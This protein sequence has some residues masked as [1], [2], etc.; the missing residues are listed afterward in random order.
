MAVTGTVHSRRYVLKEVI[1]QGGMGVVYR[2]YD[3]ETR[4]DVTLKT[5][6]DISNPAM[7][8][9]FRKECDVLAQLN[10]P[11]I[12]DIYDI[13]EFVD[14]AGK[15]QPYFVMPLLPGAT[16]DRLIAGGS[17]RLA[18]E[19]T[20]EI[21]VQACRGLHAA[22]ERGLIHR[23][24][25]PSNI[26]VLEDDSVKLIDFGVAHLSTGHSQTSVK[27][28][29]HY[30]APEQLQSRKPTPASDLFSLGVV[31]YEALT[32]RKPFEG[33]SAD[34]VVQAIL[35]QNPP[36][37]SEL[38]PSVNRTLSQVI[39]K[40]LAKHPLHRFPSMRDFGENL[41]KALRGETIEIF[42]ESRMLARIERA[43]RALLTG[44]LEFA[45]EILTGLEAEGYTHPDMPPM[46]RDIDRAQREK[47]IT[48][49]LESAG[50]CFQEDEYQL[51]LQKVQEILQIEPRHTGAIALQ[52]EIESK[53]SSE[54][55][56]KWMALARQHLDN[57]AYSHARQALED[58]LKLNPDHSE[59]RKMLSRLEFREL[60][61][62]RVR[63]EKENRY[64]AALEAW[65]K[66][67]VS[68]ALSELEHMMT[69]IRQAPDMT[70]P[71]RAARYQN[72]YNQV[73]SDHDALQTSYETARKKLSERDFKTALELCVQELAK[74]PG[75]ALFQALKVDVEEAQRQDLSA[76]IARV[77]REVEVEPDPERRVSILR[78]A[79][80]AYPGE[81]HFERALQLAVS[82]RDLVAGIVA[83]ARGYEERRQ[84]AEA[85]NQWEMLRNIYAGYP[86]LEFEIERLVKRRDQQA[87][88]DAKSRWVQQI[89]QSLGLLDWTRALELVANALTEFPGDGELTVLDQLAR[90][91]QAKALQVETLLHRG[92][93]L[94]AEGQLEE[95]IQ[96]LRSASEI[97][98]RNLACRSAL[99]NALLQKA[100]GLLETDS[101]AAA[102]LINEALA[103][104]PANTLAK[105][106]RTL[107]GDRN[108]DQ[109]V[110]ECLSQ[111]RQLQAAGR[112]Q[113]ALTEIN[114]ALAS[115]PRESR[116]LQLKTSLE[117]SMAKQ[118]RA[119]LR[120]RDLQEMQALEAKGTQAAD[121]GELRTVL[122]RTIA[123][124][125]PYN[126]DK[127]FDSIVE[128]LR[129]RLGVMKP[130]PAPEAAPI[131][132]A[133]ATVAQS[134]AAPAPTV[135]A[136]PARIP[137]GKQSA[138]PRKW[139]PVLAG[140]SALLIALAAFAIYKTVHKAASS[141]ASIAFQLNTEP[142][143]AAITLDG[144]P[145]GN[146]PLRAAL[147]QGAHVVRISLPGY[148]TV[149]RTWNITP[150]F[151]PP[152]PERLE[153][154]PIRLQVTSD[155]PE[156][157]VIVD[158]EGK[159]PAAAGAPLDIPDV[160]LNSRH[161]LQLAAAG[162]SLEIPFEA[163]AA[164]FPAI[165]LSA[166][167]AA[168]PPVF[169]VST[170]GPKGR[171][172]SSAK[173]RLSVDGGTSYRDAGPEGLDLEQLPGD[174]VLAVQDAGG[175]TRTLTVALDPAPMVQTFLLASRPSANAGS[176]A[177]DSPESEFVVLIDGKR[178]SYN[179]KGPPY[180]IYNIPAGTHQ[181]QLQKE[182]YRIEPDSLSADVK[183]NRSVLLKFGMAPLP[184]GLAIQNAIP[185]TRVSIASR[186]LGVTDSRGELRAE[187]T[188]G[189][190]SIT[191]SK[192]GYKP[193]VLNQVLSLGV[194]WG[195]SAPQ[196][197]LDPVSGTITL[198]KDPARGMRLGIRQTSGIVPPQRQ[199]FEEAPDELSLPVGQYI[200][201]FE[202]QGYRPETVGPVGLTEGQNITIPVKLERR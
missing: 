24:V 98:S 4:R 65:R 41:Q 110:D 109:F 153:P 179:R 7:L 22:H 54:Q 30:M 32:R 176:I 149:E 106:L 202:A 166:A 94:C 33:A 25:K 158:G 194:Q 55:I 152:G 81:S 139:I 43:R 107:L 116:L 115:Y 9:L 26:F 138:P 199:A 142:S 90:Q 59:A 186:S 45:G 14:A 124:A 177:V 85:L 163:G 2:A 15:R 134:A 36:P 68:S 34:D 66:G 52:N 88:I 161:T 8:D 77:D 29:L 162:G 160:S 27:G 3:N 151:T 95:G 191:L 156:M 61:Y 12:V 84:F 96:S 182:G 157:K 171:F 167:P 108:R 75:H 80:A 112:L 57:N 196:S 78:Q 100:R 168:L 62:V 175:N 97:D 49:L 195:I 64:Q 13:G 23:D 178:F 146:A 201:T 122:E 193:R 136:A 188:P 128:F 183:P 130:S 76:Y 89:D 173:V 1:G 47:T 21:M 102:G 82:K 197:R 120:T 148:K 118:E 103:L 91:G 44:E 129:A 185:G 105:T 18:V 164:Q 58:V 46:R 170:V 141:T 123:I 169:I 67:E 93:A 180:A 104:E 192:D 35:N 111:S 181:V 50:R 51:A 70:D 113:D 121:T 187:L 92:K 159:A 137:P 155:V 74:Y 135:E 174:G 101:S 189:T 28:T 125:A 190:Y 73:R 40:A 37:A 198:R 19:R 86:G 145:A 5:L 154:L 150:G 165:Q 119:V 72:F 63:K 143:G 71:D 79:I 131:E 87:R 69:L 172:Y 200:L 16:L 56:G 140:A 114:K 48:R 53:R 39:Q 6:L 83:R 117:G 60:E 99:T 38:N 184:T 11:N 127:E 144:K 17:H 20:V 42:D 10:H 133:A 132:P 147:P 31:C 126:G